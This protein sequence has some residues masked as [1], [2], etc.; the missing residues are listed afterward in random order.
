M[1]TSSESG[2]NYVVYQ[3]KNIFV[4]MWDYLCELMV[5]N[6]WE[7]SLVFCFLAAGVI[8]VI[9]VLFALASVRSLTLA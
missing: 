4:S 5:N 1:I 2:M 3:H 9:P 7:R 6:Y 8:L